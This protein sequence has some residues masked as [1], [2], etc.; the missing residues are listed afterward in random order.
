MTTDA[1]EPQLEDFFQRAIENIYH[2]LGDLADEVETIYIFLSA[3][4]RMYYCDFF[5]RIHGQVV[6][7]HQLEAVAKRKYTVSEDE[8]IAALEKGAGHAEEME[9]LFLKHGQEAPAAMKM[10]FSPGSG[11]LDNTIEYDPL[12]SDTPEDGPD[13]AFEDWFAEIAQ[14]PERPE[15]E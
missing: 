9:Q 11:Q 6:K 8:W 12:Y 15:E 5:F 1:F 4:Q 3:E 14:L 13:E 7:K 10:I 2:C